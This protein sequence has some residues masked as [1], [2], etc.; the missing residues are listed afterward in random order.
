M[1]KFKSKRIFSIDLCCIVG[2]ILMIGFHFFSVS[3]FESIPISSAISI[4]TLF[5]RWI[6]MTGFPLILMVNGAVFFR[7]KFSLKS[8]KRLI[9]LLYFF[10]ISFLSVRFCSSERL[11][12][13][14]TINEFYTFEGASFGIIYAGLFLIAPFLA[15]LYKSL[16]DKRSKQIL[17]IIMCI[18][19]SLPT[20]T[21]VFGIKLLPQNFTNLY[22]ITLFFIGAYIYENRK[23]FNALNFGVL[24]GCLCLSEAILSY[25]SST[26]SDTH[27][28]SSNFLDSYGSIFNIGATSCLFIIM[29]KIRCHSH[30]IRSF[31]KYIAKSILPIIMVSWILEEKIIKIVIGNE[32]VNEST[33]LKY[34]PLYFLI[35]SAICLASASIV[36]FPFNIVC[37]I[38][39]GNTQNDT[40]LNPDLY[41]VPEIPITETENK[42]EKISENISD[43]QIFNREYSSEPAKT[44]ILN[45][46]NEPKPV[47][48]EI[49][50][51]YEQIPVN[52]PIKESIKETVPSREPVKPL[53]PSPTPIQKTP[54]TLESILAEKTEPQTQPT[55]DIDELINL[56]SQS[57]K[58][59]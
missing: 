1:S 23:N 49:Q 59:K 14:E 52:E 48:R 36:Q 57:R 58:G 28:F 15:L 53:K 44:P 12:L 33:I 8:Y 11:N 47:Q 2:I 34:F 31:V 41:E 21:V 54:L 50:T 40:A 19:T 20:L 30:A 56:I 45:E 5:I 4:P 13:R 38:F 7:K 9:K 24:F 43:T 22:P 29:L 6:C 10:I 51:H 17:L 39:K 32:S 55:N 35:T 16:P 27:T 25:S 46:F 3:G 18:L 37:A 26:N 42:S